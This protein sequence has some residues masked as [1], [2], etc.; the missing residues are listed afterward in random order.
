MVAGIVSSNAQVYSANVVGYVNVSAPAGQFVL[1]ANPFT[2]GDDVLSN[3]VQNVAGASTVN[4]WN[5]SGFTTA[6]YKGGLHQWQLA[7]NIN[8]DN[9]AVPPGVGFFLNASATTNVTFIGSVVANTGGGTATNVLTGVTVPVGSLIPYVDVVT[10][11][12]TINLQVAGAS[13]LNQWNVSAQ[14]FQPTFT[15]KG[16]LHVWQ[17]PGNVTTNPVI[18]AAE[19][20]FLT[21]AGATNWVETLQ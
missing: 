15:Y 14:A 2:T 1:A 5:G 13:T 21:P 19:G 10:N 12:T 17:Q 18:H 11:T 20:F 8:A 9:T 7:G 4:F 16:G 6:T 3:V